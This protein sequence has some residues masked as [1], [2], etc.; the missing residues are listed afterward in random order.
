MGCN[1]RVVGDR[2]LSNSVHAGVPVLPRGSPVHWDPLPEVAMV[3]D[4]SGAMR[5]G[6]LAELGHTPWPPSP[7]CRIRVIVDLTDPLAPV[8][9]WAGVIDVDPATPS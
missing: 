5:T 6:L 3:P 9:E 8:P 4:T 1:G 7:P 2:G